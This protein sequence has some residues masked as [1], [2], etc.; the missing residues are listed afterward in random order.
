MLDLHVQL[1]SQPFRVRAFASLTDFT[2]SP[3]GRFQR[4]IDG[5]RDRAADQQ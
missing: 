1:L 3:V 4:L 5:V 2:S